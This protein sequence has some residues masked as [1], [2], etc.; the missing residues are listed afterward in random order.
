MRENTTTASHRFYGEQEVVSNTWNSFSTI[1]IGNRV[2]LFF[3][4]VEDA[5]RL[6]LQMLEAIRNTN[7]QEG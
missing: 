6:T 2:T 7:R 4:T 1:W 3:E 5:E